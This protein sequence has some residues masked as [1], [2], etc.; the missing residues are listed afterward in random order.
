[1]AFT[2]PQEAPRMAAMEAISSSIWMHIPCTWGSRLASRSAISVAG[3]MGYPAKKRQ[4]A[5][6]AP[7]AQ[8]SSPLIKNSPVKIP[9][10]AMAPLLSRSSSPRFKTRGEISRRGITLRIFWNN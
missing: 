5:A 1:M 6:M 8:A 3:V 10:M 2:P 7:S 9:G 4:P